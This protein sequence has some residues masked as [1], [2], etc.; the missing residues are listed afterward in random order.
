WSASTAPLGPLG[1]RPSRLMEHAPFR[2]ANARSNFGMQKPESRF[3]RWSCVR[4]RLVGWRSPAM[5]VALLP[6]IMKEKRFHSGTLKP[7]RK[8]TGLRDIQIKS[9]PWPF[10][11]MGVFSLP[12]GMTKRFAFG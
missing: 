5:A 1:R 2:P 9:A 7:E 12:P 4:R 3:E 10:H 6:P 11:R 8:Y